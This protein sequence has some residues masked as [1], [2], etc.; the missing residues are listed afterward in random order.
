ME[1]VRVSC[2]TLPQAAR[3]R[4][5][6][7]KTQHLYSSKG[8]LFLGSHIHTRHIIIT[9]LWDVFVGVLSR[10]TLKPLKGDFFRWNWVL[11]FFLLLLFYAFLMKQTNLCIYSLPYTLLR[12][13]IVDAGLLP[14]KRPLLPLSHPLLLTGW[15]GYVTH[16]C[17]AHVAT[18]IIDG[19]I[20]TD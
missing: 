10:I 1:S 3:S 2:S 8:K 15:V 7:N 14:S 6:P 20:S 11:S 4:A 16:L 9:F 12:Y 18:A 17:P 13:M 19:N 5:C